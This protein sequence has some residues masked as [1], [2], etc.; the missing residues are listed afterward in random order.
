MPHCIVCAEAGWE[1]ELVLKIGS[2]SF[3][4]VWKA[5]RKNR[6]DGLSSEVALKFPRLG[7]ADALRQEIAV[8]RQLVAHRGVVGCLD[9]I[10]ES[11]IR[12]SAPDLRGPCLVMRS[13]DSDL[14][15]FL[16]KHGVV[17][18]SLAREWCKQLADAVAHVHFVGVVHRDIKPSNILV[19]FDT[20]IG[21]HGF[22]SASVA[23]ADFGGARRLP[24]PAKRRRITGKSQRDAVGRTMFAAYPM[25]A[26]V[27]TFWYRAP[28]LMA[29]NLDRDGEDSGAHACRYGTPA[30]VWS[31]GAV[32]YEILLGKPLARAVDCVDAV[33]CLLG[34][35]G[36]CFDAGPGAPEYTK[37]LKWQAAVKVASQRES[38]RSPMPS[39]AQWD[40]PRACLQWCPMQRGT[41]AAMSR[42]PWILGTESSHLN[43]AGASSPPTPPPSPGRHRTVGFNSAGLSSQFL[44]LNRDWSL[45]VNP[46]TDGSRCAC[47]G[48]CRMA[49][50]RRD[51]GCDCNTSCSMSGRKAI[52]R[53]GAKVARRRSAFARP[54]ATTRRIATEPSGA[55]VG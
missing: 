46:S 19:F 36:P 25:T 1:Y 27:C 50:H 23:L 26:R 8:M 52:S 30:D 51:G 5:R 29:Y 13:A 9:V 48:N 7:A 24:F 28:E 2:G 34:V 42:M 38:R 39:G 17:G 47:S 35:L 12:A 18:E 6:Q 3:G 11:D 14:K 37:Q 43:L 55:C 20:T 31:Y 45:Q 15:H 22:L 10:S 41:A 4:S 53:S 21:K 49:K 32:V 16:D 40:V 44:K 33:S 54:K